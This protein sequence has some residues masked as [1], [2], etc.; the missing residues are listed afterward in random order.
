MEKLTSSLLPIQRY[1]LNLHDAILKHSS[2]SNN[3]AEE[4]RETSLTN[5]SHED[6]ERK[7]KW[8]KERLIVGWKEEGLG[9]G[10]DDEEYLLTYE[11]DLNRAFV[12]HQGRKV[13]GL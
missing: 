2:T 12:D 8:E 6:E 9:N 7:K 5:A 13:K 11:W 1:A 4:E 3:V 10:L